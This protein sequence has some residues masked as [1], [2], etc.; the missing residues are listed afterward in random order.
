ME[1][2]EWTEFEMT[3]S[4]ECQ[5]ETETGELEYYYC[6]GDCYYEAIDSLSEFIKPWQEAWGLDNDTRMVVR[7][8][9]MGWRHASGYTFCDASAKSIVEALSLNTEWRLL[10]GLEAGNRLVVN[11]YSHDEPVGSPTFVFEIAGEEAE[12]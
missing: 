7:G 12:A 3:N 1:T 6:G 11:R 8:T 10:F 9:S 2:L 5:V 4:C